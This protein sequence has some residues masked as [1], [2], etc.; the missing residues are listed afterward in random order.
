M[1]AN[2]PAPTNNNDQWARRRPNVAASAP[3]WRYDDVGHRHPPTGWLICD[4]AGYSTTTY[5]NLFAAIG[6]TFG[7]SGGTFNVP[8]FKA[9]SPMGVGTDTIQGTGYNFTLGLQWGEYVHTPK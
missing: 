5:A 4:G 7:G 6:Y 3:R 2:L 9:R 1:R 8:N